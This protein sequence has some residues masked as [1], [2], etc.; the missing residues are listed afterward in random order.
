MEN[1]KY[2]ADVPRLKFNAQEYFAASSSVV[3]FSVLCY[4]MYAYI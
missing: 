2:T 4:V 1:I 3:L